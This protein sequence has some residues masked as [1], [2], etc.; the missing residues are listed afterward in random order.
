MYGI[1]NS[2]WMTVENDTASPRLGDNHFTHGDTL[3]AGSEPELEAEAEPQPQPQPQAARGRSSSA[4]GQ[5]TGKGKG[6]GIVRRVKGKGST[7]SFQTV[8]SC[9]W[10]GQLSIPYSLSEHP[11]GAHPEPDPKVRKTPSWPR[12]WAN[13]SH[14]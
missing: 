9:S 14:F 3:F 4:P 7:S 12:S 1:A 6:K 5:G 11:D 10:S 8:N 2:L 13:F